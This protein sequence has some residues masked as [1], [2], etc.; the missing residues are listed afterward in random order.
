MKI[1][2]KIPQNCFQCN[3]PQ[4]GWLTMHSHHNSGFYTYPTITEGIENKDLAFS[5]PAIDLEGCKTGEH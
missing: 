4:R 3:E 2:I 5:Q 1:L